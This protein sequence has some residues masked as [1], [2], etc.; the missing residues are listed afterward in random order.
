M[1]VEVR[2]SILSQR[3]RTLLFQ[4]S[5]PEVVELTRIQ[6]GIYHSNPQQHQQ[7]VSV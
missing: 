7:L 2:V 1:Y 5:V 4:L 3:P 6:L